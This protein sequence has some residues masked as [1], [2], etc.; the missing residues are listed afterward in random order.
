[1]RARKKY[2]E[3]LERRL[4]YL[5]DTVSKAGESKAQF[6]KA[7]VAALTWAIPVLKLSISTN[8]GE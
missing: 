3:T 8:K 1:M 2:V 5:R 4:E 6:I 7:E